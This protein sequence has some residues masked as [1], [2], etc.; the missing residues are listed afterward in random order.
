MWWTAI[1][2]VFEQPATAVAAL[3]SAAGV[4]DLKDLFLAVYLEQLWSRSKPDFRTEKSWKNILDTFYESCAN[5]LKDFHTSLEIFTFASKCFRDQDFREKFVAQAAE[6][7][8]RN[9]IPFETQVSFVHA[10]AEA[11]D[12]ERSAQAAAGQFCNL[13]GESTERP[14]DLTEE[15]TASLSFQ[16][17]L[18][19]SDTVLDL[20]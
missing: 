10:T 2:P 11:A 7:C 20:D 6:V 19:S 13:Q 1:P 12:F 8:A 3:T 16:D 14:I 17:A 4:E 18:S 9:S 5:R 15:R